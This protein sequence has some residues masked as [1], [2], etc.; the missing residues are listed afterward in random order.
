MR[1]VDCSNYTG[2]LRAEVLAAWKAAGVGLVIAQAIEPPPAYPKGVT[3]QQIA[4]CAAA[5]LATDAYVW[6]W[7]YSDVEADIAAKLGLLEGL[8]I[9]RVWVDAEDTAAATPAAHIQAVE[10][11]LAVVDAWGAERGLPKAGVYTAWWWWRDHLRC[12]SAGRH[13]VAPWWDRALWDAE[14]DGVADNAVGWHPFGGWSERRVKQYAGTSTLAGQGGID[15]NVLSAAEADE[16]LAWM[17]RERESEPG[18]SRSEGPERAA[19]QRETPG[20]WP[21]PTWYEAAVNYRGVAD[22][23][24]RQLAAA[25]AETPGTLRALAEIHRLSAPV[26]PAD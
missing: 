21:W 1:A 24:G 23:L 17:Q 15:L 18:G 13:A 10:R 22:E 26:G 3:R 12:P 2:A 16:V 8:P 4:A 19:S 9:R 14:Y 25:G 20:D 7:T 11:A 6:C 5:G